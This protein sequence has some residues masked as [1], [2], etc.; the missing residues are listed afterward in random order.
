MSAAEPGSQGI[1]SCNIANTPNPFQFCQIKKIKK[2]IQKNKGYF[3]NVKWSQ[4]AAYGLGI[5]G[6][7]LNI[8]GREKYGTVLHGQAGEL[9][10]K[11][12]RD[13]LNLI[14]DE[15]GDSAVSNVWVVPESERRHNPHAPDLI[16]GWNLG[17]RTSWDSILGSFSRD[18]IS[19]NR[20]KWSGDHEDD[21]KDQHYIRHRRDIDIGCHTGDTGSSSTTNCHVSQ[22]SVSKSNRPTQNLSCPFRHQRTRS[23]L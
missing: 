3:E 15:T 11:I 14:D 8:R 13:L 4:T 10:K 17:Y 21:K 23:C 20:D 9:R 16:V 6:I 5:N 12:K 7:Y 2:E 18:V 22:T 1:L 19:D